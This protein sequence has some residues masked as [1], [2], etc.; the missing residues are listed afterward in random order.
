MDRLIQQRT[1]TSSPK[2]FFLSRNYTRRESGDDAAEDPKGPLGLNTLYDPLDLAIADL[3]FVHGLGGGSRST[4]TKSGEPSRY[5]PLEWLPKDI[6]FRDVRIH[7]FGYNS[8]WEKEGIGNIYDFAKSLLGCIYD[9]PLMLQDSNVCIFPYIFSH[10][11][12]PGV[13]T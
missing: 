5:W 3:I 1:N 4:W 11:A 6:G 13:L 7:S 8:N 9:C 2:P 12:K 10:T